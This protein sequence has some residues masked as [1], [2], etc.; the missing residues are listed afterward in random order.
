MEK[1]ITALVDNLGIAKASEFWTSFRYGSKD[2]VQVKKK[3]FGQT[4]IDVLYKDIKRF[5]GKM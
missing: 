1:A 4:T 2:Y 3:I 5:E